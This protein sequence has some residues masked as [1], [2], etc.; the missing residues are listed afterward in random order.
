[1]SAHTP[2]KIKSGDKL[3]SGGSGAEAGQAWIWVE[4]GHA[5]G[6]LEAPDSRIGEADPEAAAEIVRRWNSH[7]DLLAALERIA[8]DDEPGFDPRRHARAAIAKARGG[9]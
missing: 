4:T 7:D 3:G 6:D 2:F 5:A 8:T 9:K 1:M